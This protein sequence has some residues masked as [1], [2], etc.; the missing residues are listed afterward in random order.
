MQLAGQAAIVTG[1]GRGIGAAAATAL[2][3]VGAEVTLAARSLDEVSAVAA[4]IRERGGRA[5]PLQL[6]VTDLNAVE[7]AIAAAAPFRILVNNAG[8]NIRTTVLDYDLED[9]DQVINLN[10]RSYFLVARTVGRHMV[11]RRYG[12][13]INITSILAAIG[14]PNQAAY[15][16]SKGGVTQLTK[17]MAIE[18]APHNVTVNC[19]GPTYFETELTR[20]LYQD[21]ER[22]SFIESRTPMGRWG[23]LDELHGAAIF[24][25]SDAAGFITGSTLSINGGQ[26]M[27]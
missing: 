4:E 9:W 19:I 22:K 5:E 3:E 27:M 12:R 14:L 17:V 2:A 6:D 25:A 21:P 8:M 1:A 23:Q 13:V 24:L 26:Y 16:T 11:E 18:W 7:A 15:A 10:L 20:P